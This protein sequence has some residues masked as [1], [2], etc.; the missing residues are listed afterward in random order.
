M[1]AVFVFLNTAYP[2]REDW[3]NLDHSEK[4]TPLCMLY[5]P[6]WTG[7]RYFQSIIITGRLKGLETALPQCGDFSMGPKENTENIKLPGFKVLPN[8]TVINE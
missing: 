6:G 8:K 7:R 3:T 4:T 2:Q 5:T 1:M